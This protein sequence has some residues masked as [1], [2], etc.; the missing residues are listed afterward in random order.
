MNVT[1][2]FPNATWTPWIIL[3]F[4]SFPSTYRKLYGNVYKSCCYMG[5]LISSLFPNVVLANGLYV[6]VSIFWR[7][8]KID[9][10]LMFRISVISNVAHRESQRF[11]KCNVRHAELLLSDAAEWANVSCDVGLK[12]KNVL[13]LCVRSIQHEHLTLTL[14]LSP[15]YVQSNGDLFSS[16]IEQFVLV[17]ISLNLQCSV[18]WSAGKWFASD[19][20]YLDGT[21]SAKIHVSRFCCTRPRL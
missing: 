15:S 5:I 12:V 3:F 14:S 11:L 8:S 7:S 6:W 18:R 13:S 9:P 17:N 2:L 1:Q 10:F 16:R 21:V 4:V 19:I 20:L